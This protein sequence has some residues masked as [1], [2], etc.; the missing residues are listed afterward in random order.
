MVQVAASKRDGARLR[1]K[2]Q[3]IAD[4]LRALIVS[5]KLSE[6]D[7]LGREPEL[8]ERFTLERVGAGAGP[9]LET[10]ADVRRKST[11]TFFVGAGGIRNQSDLEAASDAGAGAWLVASALH[12]GGLPRVRG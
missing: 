11:A 7:S 4:E 10:L 1:E 8:V 12:D 5:G 3:Q 6:G 2:P 9:D